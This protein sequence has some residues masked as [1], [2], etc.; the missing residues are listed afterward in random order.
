MPIQILLADD[1]VIFR[2]GLRALLERAEMTVMGEASDGHEA[3][4]LAHE[5]HP[6][7]AVLDI[8]M[9]YLNGLETAR[10]LREAVP[11]TKVIL[12]TV[13]T[14]TPYILE[15][16]HAGVSG[17]VLKTQAAVDLVQAIRDVL[18]GTIYLLE[19]DGYSGLIMRLCAPEAF[20]AGAARQ[21]VPPALGQSAT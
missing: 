8:T 11:R 3:L 5:R 15:A 2:Q 10:R 7:V 19:S 13:H 1:H 16:I 12:L 9:P 17:Y 4:R 6:D 18:Q 14:E 21:N 20:F